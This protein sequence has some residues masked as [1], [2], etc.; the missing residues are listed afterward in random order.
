MSSELHAVLKSKDLLMLQGV[1]DAA[2]YSSASSIK[3]PERYNVAAKLL[4]ERL[5]GG[6]T[7][8]DDLAKELEKH[9]GS[10]LSS[11][12]P[13]SFERTRASIQGRPL[14]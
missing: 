3:H 13:P 12:S 7:S 5:Q 10:V 14:R 4:V 9:F 8:A 6:M 1:L 2:G 11:I